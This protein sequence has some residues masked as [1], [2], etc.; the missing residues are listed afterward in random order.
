MMQQG[1]SSSLQIRK[2]R[3]VDED[4]VYGIGLGSMD[5]LSFGN[6]GQHLDLQPVGGKP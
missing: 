2:G 6:L 1:C 5:G 3:C 4:T